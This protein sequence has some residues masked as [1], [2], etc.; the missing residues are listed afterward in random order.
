MLFSWT[1][2]EASSLL[3]AAPLVFTAVCEESTTAVCVCEGNRGWKVGV[4]REI[5]GLLLDPDMEEVLLSAGS[6]SLP[7]VL[8]TGGDL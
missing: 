5:I 2:T 1:T 8:S 3:P 6:W 7:S 4:V